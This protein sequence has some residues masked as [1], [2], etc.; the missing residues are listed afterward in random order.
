MTQVG[1]NRGGGAKHCDT[2]FLPFSDFFLSKILVVIL[3]F[4]QG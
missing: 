3:Q 1:Q 4:L 2:L